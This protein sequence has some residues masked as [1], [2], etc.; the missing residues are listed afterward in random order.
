MIKKLNYAT[1]HSFSELL[2]KS[3]I[4]ILALDVLNSSDTPRKDNSSDCL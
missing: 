2:F 1:F 4:K 3:C